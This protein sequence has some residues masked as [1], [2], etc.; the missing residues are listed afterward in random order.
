[1][2]RIKEWLFNH[3]KV[4]SFCCFFLNLFGWNS[5]IKNLPHT[6][7]LRNTKVIDKGQGNKISIKKRSILHDC[8]I[9][10]YGNNNCVYIGED[11]FL[12]NLT[13]WI[14]DNGNC[15]NIGNNTTIHGIT[16]LACIEGCSITVGEDCM[17][18]SN[19]S[20]RTGDSHSVLD[21]DGN[22]INSSKSITVGNHVW[23]GQ[24]AYLGKGAYIPDS[25]VV[26]ACSVITK[27]FDRTHVAIGGNPA[28]IIKENI[29]WC[30]ERI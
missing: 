22:R 24:N 3:E 18:S 6:C 26:G 7:W 23:I 12:R 2:K 10:F 30:R 25:S 15:I 27:K 29:D 14:E 20:M 19:V 16:N 13:I 8:V 11:C 17:F 5:R 9:K 4:Y 28:K 21:L 1:M